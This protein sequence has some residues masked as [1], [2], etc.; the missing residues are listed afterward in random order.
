[1]TG[2]APTTSDEHTNTAKTS[3]KVTVVDTTAPS[4]T[5]PANVTVEATGPGGANGSYDTPTATDIVDGTIQVHCDPASGSTF[6]VG[7]TTVT[8]TATDAHGNSASHSFTVTVQDTTA[9]ELTLPANQV[10]EAT[11]KAGTPVSFAATAKDIVDGNLAVTCAP[12]S[13]SEFPLGGTTVECSATDAHGNKA[14]GSFSVTVQDTAKPVV[15]VPATITVEATGPNGAAVTYSGVSARDD[16]DGVLPVTCDLASGATFALGTATVICSATDASGNTGTNSFDILVKDTTG[17]AI[18]VPAD[19]NAVAT[20]AAGA[21]VTYGAVTAN[22]LVD[23]IVA[24]TCDK[25]SGSAFPLG[26]TTVTC[27]AKDKAGNES[28]KSF[29]VNVTVSWG[30]FQQ[31]INVD[32]SSVFKSGS[33]IPV[34]FRLSGASAAVTNLDARLYWTKVSNGVAGSEAEGVS[35]SAASEGNQFRYSDGQYIFNLSTK[36]MSGEGT[37]QPGS[38]SVTASATPSWC[39]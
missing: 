9:P 34:K 19:V 31:P 17:P 27:A 28:T 6:P 26:K 33:T 29:V 5:V 30:D 10:V 25:A 8:C 36:L 13:G 23:G 12:A 11:A 4:F 37:Y 35:T 18:T 7:S 3:F 20:T 24:A 1:M 22:D 32:G 16:I 14:T 38:T 21:T 2:K 39:P 15:T